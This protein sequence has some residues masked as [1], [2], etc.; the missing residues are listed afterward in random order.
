M[1]M[2][3]NPNDKTEGGADLPP[4]K[5]RFRVAEFTEKAFQTGTNGVA[6][7]F[8]VDINGKVITSYLNFFYTKKSLWR[9]E[10]F[11]ESVGFDFSRPPEAHA[12]VG[13][14]GVA[15]FGPNDKGYLEPKKFYPA[16]AN[17]FPPVT[18]T[19]APAAQTQGQ[20]VAGLKSELPAWL[21]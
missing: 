15:D 9:L 5:Y 4:G 1:A 10:K 18:N 2:N 14:V 7:R 6:A 13:A 17:N 11:F 8:D 21:A 19:A 16:S 3:Y 12:V 20:Q